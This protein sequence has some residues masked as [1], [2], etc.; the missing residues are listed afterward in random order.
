MA[1]GSRI[2]E[3]Y[4]WLK[5]ALDL[6]AEMRTPDLWDKS[7][8]APEEADELSRY[9]K[10]ADAWNSRSLG[11]AGIGDLAS[12]QNRFTAYDT[13]L[14][15]IDPE[16]FPATEPVKTLAI[17]LTELKE[18]ARERCRDGAWDWLRERLI[19]GRLVSGCV[20]SMKPNQAPHAEDWWK[21]ENAKAH[22]R[23]EHGLV[24]LG[25]DPKGKPI[26][27]EPYLELEALRDALKG[28]EKPDE[29]D[30]TGGD[31]QRGAQIDRPNASLANMKRALKLAEDFMSSRKYRPLT[32]T[33]AEMSIVGEIFN[34]VSRDLIRD[35]VTGKKYPTGKRVSPKLL[36]N[37]KR[38]IADCRG[39]VEAAIIEHKAKKKQ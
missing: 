12:L 3:K 11:S 16:P 1:L 35:K 23:G 14:S 6:V 21:P 10:A 38:E 32:K 30:C 22:A 8:I 5:D 2:P 31:E 13:W 7:A 20:I 24:L 15:Q 27:G 25:F 9:K 28:G 33:E 19:D 34:G 18:E 39:A 26:T 17:E 4:I 37:R 36:A 29:N